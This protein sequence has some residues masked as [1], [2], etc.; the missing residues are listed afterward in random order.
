[1]HVVPS[2]IL[3]LVVPIGWMAVGWYCTVATRRRERRAAARNAE[4]TAMAATLRDLDHHLDL[5]WAAEAQRLR[6]QC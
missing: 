2:T 1:M 4:W 6:R 5:V 3:G